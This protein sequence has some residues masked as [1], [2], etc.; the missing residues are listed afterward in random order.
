[1][2][3]TNCGKEGDIWTPTN[4]TAPR[5]MSFRRNN[6]IKLVSTFSFP[7]NYE[8]IVWNASK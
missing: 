5:E 7:L 6:T 3:F 2:N 8:L 1:M 4:V